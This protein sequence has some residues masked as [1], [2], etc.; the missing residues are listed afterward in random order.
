MGLTT[1]SGH[2]V[3]KQ[4]ITVSKNYLNKEELD[5]LNRIVTMFGLC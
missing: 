1:W 3:R 5:S 2:K 4:D